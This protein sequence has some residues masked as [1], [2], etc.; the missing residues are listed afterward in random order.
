M[1]L[2]GDE[3]IVEPAFPIT[4]VDTTGAGDVFRAAFIYALLNEYAA[5]RDAAI[6][7][8]GGG[9]VVHARRRHGGRAVARRRSTG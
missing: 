4:A 8:R 7:E 6:C 1:L 2:V 3:L 5:A 9:G